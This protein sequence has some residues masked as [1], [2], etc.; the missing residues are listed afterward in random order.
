MA[1]AP[2]SLILLKILFGKNYYRDKNQVSTIK[3]MRQ[4]LSH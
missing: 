4:P 1:A 2:E 3:Q